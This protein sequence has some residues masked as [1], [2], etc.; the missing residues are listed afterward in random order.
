[1]KKKI[2]TFKV[3]HRTYC[4][5]CGSKIVRN[6]FRSYCCTKCR[7]KEYA[8]RYKKYR[9]AFQLARYDRLHSKPSLGKMQ[10]EICGRWYIQVCSHAYLRHGMTG[11][12]Y[13]KFIGKDIKRG[14]IPEWYR[15]KKHES[16]QANW[17]KIK[18]N[19]EAG[20][21]Y[22]FKPGDPRAG[23]YERSPETMERL[24]MGTKNLKDNK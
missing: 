16:N 10:C 11:R 19:L 18:S 22:W 23:R 17:D 24:H 3:E 20:K 7:N 21:K 12:E 2:R 1:M 5:V 14:Y 9:S 13:R 6:R 4:R 15:E 8:Q